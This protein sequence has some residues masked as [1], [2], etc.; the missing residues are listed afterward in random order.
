MKKEN[1]KAKQTKIKEAVKQTDILHKRD[2]MLHKRQENA[3]RNETALV[4]DYLTK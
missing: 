2:K 3:K 4:A 1:E